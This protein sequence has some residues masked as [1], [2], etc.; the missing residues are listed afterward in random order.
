MGRRRAFT[1]IELLV[2]IAVIVLLVALLLPALQRVRKQTKAVIC[3]SN[4]RQWGICFNSY[5]QDNDGYL[6]NGD[7]SDWRHLWMEALWPYYRTCLEICFCP[8]TTKRSFNPRGQGNEIG[9]TF[10]T[11]SVFSGNYEWDKEGFFGSYGINGWT[12]N[13]PPEIAAQY[14]GNFP[15]RNNWRR[16][17]VKEAAYIPLFLDCC[18]PD[19]WMDHTYEPPEH[20]DEST[21][22]R[23]CIDRHDGHVNGVFLDGSVRKLGLKELWTLKWHRNFDTAGAWT[24][25][26]GVQPEDWPAWMRKFKDY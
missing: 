24:K 3:L 19:G 1:L 4:L 13:P 23:F 22:I 7:I 16:L 2:V 20:E 26:G 11:W 25:T 9:D 17:D 14:N 21:W 8:T 18:W 6:H 10:T 12:R 5:A 15:T